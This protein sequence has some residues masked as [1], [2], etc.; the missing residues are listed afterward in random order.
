MKLTLALAVILLPLSSF[1]A[2]YKATS[3]V[4]ANLPEELCLERIQQSNIEGFLETKSNNDSFPG[5][6]KIEGQDKGAFSASNTLVNIWGGACGESVLAVLKVQG[7]LVN[8]K[9]SEQALKVTLETEITND[10]CH[11]E[12]QKEVISYELAE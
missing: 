2:C 7:K 8:G 9:I 5:I 3:Y 12:A 4:P 11:V 10:N 1:G 6:L